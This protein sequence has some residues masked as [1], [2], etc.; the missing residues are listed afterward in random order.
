VPAAQAQ[1]LKER[2]P[3]IPLFA[4]PETEGVKVPLGWL[5][6]Q[7]LHLRGFAQGEARLFERQALVIV[8]SR[9][10]SAR[11]VRALAQK[12]KNDV[13]EKIGIEIQEEVSAL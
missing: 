1:A 13:R 5:L 12:I 9:K 7:V 4:M 6:D 3:G 2:Y 8:A 10:A 11:D